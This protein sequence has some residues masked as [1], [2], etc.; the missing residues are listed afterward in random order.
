MVTIAEA[1]RF[2][3]I[4][5]HVSAVFYKFFDNY[6]VSVC[7]CVCIEC[8]HFMLNIGE[9]WPHCRHIYKINK[10]LIHDRQ[11]HKPA[12]YANEAVYYYGNNTK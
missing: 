8:I 3:L 4:E 5:I 11:P 10:N 6:L 12:V 7:L 1:A 2:A 9:R